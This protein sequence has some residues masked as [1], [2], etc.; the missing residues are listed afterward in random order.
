M[1]FWLRT[2]VKVLSAAYFLLTSV[3]CLMAYL[4]YTYYA[5]IKAPPNAWIPW[6]A[7]HHIHIYWVLLLCAM[8]AYWP[9]KKNSKVLVFFGASTL[10]GILLAF[11]PF[12]LKLQNNSSAYAWSIA[13]LAPIILMALSQA[14]VNW[15]RGSKPSQSSLT[16]LPVVVAAG[17]VCLIT[18]LG[19]KLE[20]HRAGQ[21]LSVHAKDFELGLWSFVTHVVLAIL[22]VSLLNLIFAIARRTSHSR[23]VQVVTI[24]TAAFAVLSVSLKNFLDTAFSFQGRASI[25]YALLF[26]PADVV[27]A[28]K[29][30]NDASGAHAQRQ[31]IFCDG[32][33]GVGSAGADLAFHDRGMGLE[34]CYPAFI[35]SAAVDCFDG[36]LL[37]IIAAATDLFSCRDHRRA[38]V[39]RNL[40]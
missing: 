33:C 2:C 36:S 24:G 21:L 14:I 32:N 38:F 9:H 12:L 20:Y 13:S 19:T 40:I 7:T 23:V 39:S 22:I 34:L 18:S 1:Q 30:P 3:Y 11:H 31:I 10:G 37:S 5:V 16:Y 4:P 29:E 25:L 35:Y 6:F 8:G 27:L 17:T 28:S 26:F 15:P